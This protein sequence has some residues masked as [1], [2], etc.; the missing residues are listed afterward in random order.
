MKLLTVLPDGRSNSK[1]T[2]YNIFYY[3]IINDRVK[4]K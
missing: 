1:K 3:D 4:Y 2:V